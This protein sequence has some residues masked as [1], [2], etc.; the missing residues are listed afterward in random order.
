[1]KS[2]TH[3]MSIFV[4]VRES[5]SLLDRAAGLGQLPTH[6]SDERASPSPGAK[7]LKRDGLQLPES[8]EVSIF[9]Q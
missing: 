2:F 6:P 1:L 9:R 8:R 7:L 4:V 3:A 5:I